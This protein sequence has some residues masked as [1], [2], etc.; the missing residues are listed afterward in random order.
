MNLLFCSSAAADNATLITE[1]RPLLHTFV[2]IKAY[3]DNARIAIEE[4]FA[5]MARV[6]DLL[7]N[8][9]KR[10]EISLI[11]KHAGRES[12]QISPETMEA[13]QVAL[14]FGNLSGG[15]LDITIGPLLKLWGF[16]KENPGID[17]NEPDAAA[18]QKAKGLVDYRALELS[19]VKNSDGL[20]QTARLN[21]RGMRIDVG[22]FAKGY[23]ADK[24]MEVLKKRG[25]TNALIAAGGTICGI[26]CKPDGALWKVAVRHPRKD[27]AFLT[28]IPLKDQAVSTSGDYERFYEKNGKRRAHIIDPRTGRPVERMQSV[29]V[30]AQ[31]GVESDA[32]STALFVLG[33]DKGIKL[34]NELP[35]GEAM[36]V[37]QEGRVVM[38]QG[39]PE[40]IVIY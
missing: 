38:S 31:T 5:E 7:N 15:A 18:L 11:N 9:D 16:A 24:A 10:S 13:L 25:I 32:L 17:G 20:L 19:T 35:G 22:S 40:K 37:T 26:G 28:F 4:A 8:Y 3:G 14:K 6:N 12:V 36:L 2:E 1:S 30:I 23:A 21:K 27:D 34:I 33:P 29:T 39:W